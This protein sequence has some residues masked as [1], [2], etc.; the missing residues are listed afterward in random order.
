[1][2]KLA[3]EA[4]IADGE[5]KL[6]AKQVPG[7]DQEIELNE[8]MA[9]REMCKVVMGENADANLLSSR[10]IPDGMSP[11]RS[12]DNG[13]ETFEHFPKR[14]SVSDSSPTLRDR[15]WTTGSRIIRPPNWLESLMKAN[16]GPEDVGRK[17]RRPR[18]MSMLAPAKNQPSVKNFL[19]PIRGG[20]DDHKNVKCVGG[21]EDRRI[22]K[23]GRR[24]KG[25]LAPQAEDDC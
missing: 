13:R 11:K 8:P 2:E 20:L 3:A 15:A 5:N 22:V 14:V 12:L 6:N 10:A 19:T 25:M 9:G 23:G 18:T 24:R 7:I 21:N 1:M 16:K 17:K 4:P